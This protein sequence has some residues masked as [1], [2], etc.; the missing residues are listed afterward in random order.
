MAIS[1]KMADSH[2]VLEPPPHITPEERLARLR[3]SKH[4]FTVNYRKQKK[5][6]GKR[7]FCYTLPE[8]LAEELAQFS[9]EN[10]FKNRGVAAEEV[11]RAGLEVLKQ[12]REGS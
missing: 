8:S 4:K 7:Q 12:Q 11:I 1:L 2:F 3:Q 5:A 6:E 10:G 9:D